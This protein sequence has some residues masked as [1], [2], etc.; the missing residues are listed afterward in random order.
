M[1]NILIKLLNVIS[2]IIYHLIPIE[3]KKSKN[4]SR[5]EQKLIENLNEETIEY[6]GDEFKKKAIFSNQWGLR[7][8]AIKNAMNNKNAGGYYLEFGCWRGTTANFFSKFVNKIY[9]FDSFLGLK[10][11][12]VGAVDR[13]ISFFKIDKSELRLNKNVVV[14]DGYVEE[15]LE[16]FLQVNN[17][18]IN[19]I[20]FDLDVYNSTKFALIKIK[21]YLVK[22]AIILFDNYFDY[23]G[24]QYGEHKALKDTFENTE[25]EYIAF[26]LSGGGVVIKIK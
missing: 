23:I 24:W 13:P 22:D 4:K 3:I 21:K 20:H 9:T 2:R 15:T 7:E 11:T 12:W 14:I 18:K 1:Q 25:Y 5:L 6:F 26:S 10:D 8:Y 17:P 16:N 19:F